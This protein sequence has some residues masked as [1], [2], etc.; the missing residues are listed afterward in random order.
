MTSDN[1]NV[2]QTVLNNNLTKF[3]WFN[4]RIGQKGIVL[5]IKPNSNEP[6]I[7]IYL[8]FK[9][10]KV[11]GRRLL[12]VSNYTENKETSTKSNKT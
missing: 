11:I 12:N 7:D 3:Q 9:Q 1:N 5:K 2:E 10:S 4:I 8:S 6:M